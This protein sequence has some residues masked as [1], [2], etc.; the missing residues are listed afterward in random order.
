M[1]PI[2]GLTKFRIGNIECSRRFTIFKLD[3]FFYLFVSWFCQRIIIGTSVF[4][5]ELWPRICH[6]YLT[7]DFWCRGRFYGQWQKYIVNFEL[8]LSWII[9]VSKWE[10]KRWEIPR[11]RMHRCRA[12]FDLKC[13]KIFV[14]REERCTVV[15]NSYIL[16]FVVHDFL[17]V[18]RLTNFSL[19]MVAWIVIRWIKI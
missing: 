9:Q 3:G 1:I 8:T 13:F 2:M 18:T 19:S 15:V 12:S 16:V 4:F 10:D 7:S 14:I 6:I 11:I 17:F 5:I